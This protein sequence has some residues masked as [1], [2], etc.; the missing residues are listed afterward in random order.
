MPQLDLGKVK[1]TFGGSWDSSK[2]YEE[3][4]IVDSA[5]GVKYISKVAVDAGTAL[6][7]KDFWEPISGQFVEKYQGALDSAP[8][9]RLD[10]TDIQIG[11]IY[12]DTTD[13]DMKVY[14]GSDNGWIDVGTGGNAGFSTKIVDSDSNVIT[15]VI[16]VV[17]KGDTT[18]TLPDAE[19]GAKLIIVDGTGDAHD[20]NITVK[21]QADDVDI[22]GSSDDL[23]CDV[24]NFNILFVYDKTNKNWL[25]GE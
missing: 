5:Y 14:D 10:G 13:N 7:D 1:I 20:H 4:T 11:D 9:K 19:D 15:N 16:T 18:M 22:N 2:N 8:D 23:V 12:L 17:N 3:L 24:D 21:A 25:I 6:S